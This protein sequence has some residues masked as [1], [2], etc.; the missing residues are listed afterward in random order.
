MTL[1]AIAIALAAANPSADAQT[2][3][4]YPPAE[5][6]A[7]SLAKGESEQAMQTLERQLETSPND[8]ALL[9]NLGIAYAQAGE[10][11]KARNMFKA[12]MSSPEHFEL[13]TAN[14]SE[15]DSRR[16]A[17]KAIAMLDRGE[18]RP[19]TNRMVMAE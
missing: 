13:E 5:L 1:T 4:A 3:D 9:I 15:M 2:Y 6:G 8:P 7:A 11:A 14:G 17:R 10:E 18:F 16:L 19:A 12:A